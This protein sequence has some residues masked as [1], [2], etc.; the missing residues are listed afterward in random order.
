[1][2]PIPETEGSE[3]RVCGRLL[4]G[5]AGS[6]SAKCM[7]VYFFGVLCVFRYRYLKRADPSSRGVLQTVVWRVIACDLET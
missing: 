5:I 6:N 1:M 4:A 2:L 7:D 3:A